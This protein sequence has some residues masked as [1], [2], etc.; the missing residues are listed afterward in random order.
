MGATL[1]GQAAALLPAAMEGPESRRNAL[2]ALASQ[3]RYDRPVDAILLLRHVKGPGAAR[4]LGEAATRL[5]R[6]DARL[7]RSAVRQAC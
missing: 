4:V 2:V 7:A 5:T 1:T 6:S 3:M